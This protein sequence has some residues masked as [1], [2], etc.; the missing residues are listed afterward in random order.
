M[1][2]D[3]FSESVVEEAALAWFEQLEFQI[4][5][6]ESISPGEPGAERGDYDQVALEGRLREALDRL[7][8]DLPDSA[9]EEAFRSVLMISS[10][11]LVE[12]N[13]TFHT[14]LVNGVE[15]EYLDGDG[16]TGHAPVRLID[17]SRS[18]RRSER[19]SPSCTSRRPTTRI[20]I[21]RP[22][23]SSTRSARVIVQR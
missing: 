17:Y 20:R 16:D 19:R 1:I 23:M 10:P 6:G 9:R 12:A 15:V 14:Y 21:A 2:Q 11:S 3:A 8:H 13:R 5:T 7:N 22:S 4:E 18:S